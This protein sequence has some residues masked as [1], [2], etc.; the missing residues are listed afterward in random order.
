MSWL[1]A[2]MVMLTATVN[3]EAPLERAMRVLENRPGA[4]SAFFASTAPELML[5]GMKFGGKSRVLCFKDAVYAQRYGP[6]RTN[7]KT[8]QPYPSARTI[9]CR[10]ER[11]AMEETIIQTMRTEILGIDLH[12]AMYSGKN[13]ALTFPNGST[14]MYRGLDQPRRI[15][16]MR[17]GLAGVDQTE[18]ISEE[19]YE[20]LNA[21][22]TQV[23]MPWSQTMSAWNPEGPGHWGYLR[24]RPDDGDGPRLD[25]KGEHFA[26]VFHAR[27]ED[28]AQ[29][30]SARDVSR[31][32]RM[33]GLHRDRLR[34]GKWVAFTGR[35]IEMWDPGVHVVDAPAAWAAWGGYPPPSWPRY[36]GID[37]G[38]VHPYACVWIAE[39]PLGYRY[40]Y[41]HDL[42]AR[43]TIDE[44]CE[45]IKRA[46]RVEIE[47]LRACSKEQSEDTMRAEI[48]WLD[49]L[50]VS[51][52]FSDHE[53]GHRAQYDAL[54]VQTRLARKE[55]RAGIETMRSLLD[56]SQPGGPRFYAVRNSLMERDTWLANAKHPTSFE[57]QI[58]RW[59]WKTAKSAGGA[60]VTKDM[61]VDEKEDAIMAATYVLHTLETQGAIGVWA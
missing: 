17:Y 18:E 27:P 54:G 2:A 33:T 35:V 22:C 6:N 20:I 14:I 34:L 30:L 58:A 32:D 59:T 21:G 56:P 7:P 57:E 25:D 3:T 26:D 5:S 10:E 8:G 16:G 61:P 41:R 11:A 50:N 12:D 9:L 60:K 24:F 51:D 37:F 39:S 55:V 31:L 13:D 38:Y 43:L 46:E 48:P 29:F 47:T 28:T 36:R 19:Q 1:L 52:C 40:L 44:Q 53:A 23:G 4:Q 15:Q 45:R 42:R 49:Q